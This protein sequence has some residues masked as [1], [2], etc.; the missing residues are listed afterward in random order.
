[1]ELRFCYNPFDK[2]FFD[3]GTSH[4]LE[5]NRRGKQKIF[6]EYIRGIIKDNILYLR[7]FYPFD[8]IVSLSFD[9]LKTK[10]NQLLKEFLAETLT[11][12]KK[13]YKLSIS[14]IKFS[15]DNRNLQGI[16]TNI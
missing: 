10:S 14:E 4:V 3:C 15:V 16:L 7:T 9:G 6:D 12:I 2:V 11:E 8:D 1:M 5:I 13:C